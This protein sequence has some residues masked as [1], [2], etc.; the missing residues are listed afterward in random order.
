MPYFTHKSISKSGAVIRGRLEARDADQLKRDLQGQGYLPIET[1]EISAAKPI[2]RRVGRL[3]GKD[4]A[5]AT[6]EITMLLDAGQTV[7]QALQ[8][9]IEGAA[10]SPLRR[11]LAAAL[12]SLREGAS[13]ERALAA[14]EAF[15]PVFLA[16]VQAGEAS[17]ALAE[18]LG[19]LATMLDRA[20][21]LKEQ[22]ISAMIYPALLMLVAIAAVILLLG[23]VVPQF[24]P[25]FADA[26]TTLPFATRAVLKASDLLRE[27]GVVFLALVSLALLGLAAALRRP[28]VADWCDDR[29]LRLPLIGPL[30]VLAATGRWMRVLALLLKG[31]VPLPTALELVRPVAGHRR[32]QAMLAAMRAGIKDGKGLTAS[33]PAKPMMPELALQL[34]RVG[35]QGGRLEDSLGHLAELFDTR[36]EQSLKRALAI[37]EPACVLVLSLVVGTIVIS[38]LLAVVSINDLAI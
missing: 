10:R 1:R 16:M 9:M 34:L 8:L 11:A 21:K 12:T 33:L 24:A 30:L 4:L 36:L 35:E 38:I 19:K 27:D 22:M 28:R 20:A 26:H 14:T 13:L 5:I 32:I 18:Q 15:P 25:L 17:G 2:W 23:L 6:H 29:L 7:E 31:G 3:G 37:F